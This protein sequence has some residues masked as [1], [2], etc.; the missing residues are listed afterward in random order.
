MGLR[1]L[2]DTA[3]PAGD[4]KHT[5]DVAGIEKGTYY[6]WLRGRQLPG[7]DRLELVVRTWGGDPREWVQKRAETERQLAVHG[8]RPAW[9]GAVPSRAAPERVTSSSGLDSLGISSVEL[10]RRE[11]QGLLESLGPEESE[12]SPMAA[13]VLLA[14]LAL[15]PDSEWNEAGR[16]AL[17]IAEIREWLDTHY[18]V[19]FDVKGQHNILR[20]CVKRLIKKGLVFIETPRQD[21]QISR[22]LRFQVP[23][24]VW[25]GARHGQWEPGVKGFLQMDSGRARSDSTADTQV[26]SW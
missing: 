22:G 21:P 23:K 8:G 20:I 18:G 13:Y 14:L 1:T 4:R 3:G 11:A 16:P 10:R 17:R 25:E 26:R 5:C 6:A 9:S 7:R 19:T 15:K 2:R 12:K 24:R